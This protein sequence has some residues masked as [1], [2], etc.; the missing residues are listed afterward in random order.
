MQAQKSLSSISA[1]RDLWMA[2]YRLE[3]FERDRFSSLAAVQ[4][5]SLKEGFEKGREEG[6]IAMQKENARNALA[7]ELP[8]VQV[9]R[10]TGLSV[11]ELKKL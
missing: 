5:K 11:E 6:R 10:I 3:L 9:S 8:L 1:D 2:Q 4:K 7:M